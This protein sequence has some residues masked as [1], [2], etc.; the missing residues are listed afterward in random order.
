VNPH[1]RLSLF[2]LTAYGITWACWIPL[3]WIEPGALHE[4]LANAGQF[5]PLVAAFIFAEDRRKLAHRMVQWRVNIICYIAAIGLPLL[6][7]ILAQIIGGESASF[8]VSVELIPH[9]VTILFIGGPLGEEA[10]WRGFAL[11]HLLKRW[12]PII[13]GGILTLIWAFWHLPLWF[14]PGAEVPKPFFIYA[15]GVAAI[16]LVMTWLHYRSNGSVLM[17]MLLHASL[18]TWTRSI[19]SSPGGSLPSHS[20]QSAASTGLLGPNRPPLS[21]IDGPLRNETYNSIPV[22][23]RFIPRSPSL[24]FAELR[25]AMRVL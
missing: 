17:A 4:I 23:P 13:A 5:G 14:I 9:L 7:V 19:T 10:G 15:L 16:T 25:T 22:D 8:D 20:S 2:L 18:N 12:S 11:P 1:L 3:V 21:R 24:A 6:A